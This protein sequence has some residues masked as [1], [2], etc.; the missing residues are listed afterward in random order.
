MVSF[1]N[2][3]KGTYRVEHHCENCNQS[4]ELYIPRGTYLYEYLKNKKC[5]CYNCGCRI[6]ALL[7]EDINPEELEKKHLEELKRARERIEKLKNRPKFLRK[8]ED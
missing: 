7:N 4:V 1:R 5:K 2:L 6:L 8:D 3:F